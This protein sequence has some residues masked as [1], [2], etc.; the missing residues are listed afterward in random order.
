M[1]SD[2]MGFCTHMTLCWLGDGSGCFRCTA[3]NSL[4]HFLPIIAT[5]DLTFSLNPGFWEI[6]SGFW[7]WWS[8]V[9][10]G[11]GGTL[12]WC[13]RL[14]F[15]GRLSPSLLLPPIFLCVKFWLTNPLLAGADPGGGGG[16]G[17]LTFVIW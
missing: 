4:A 10:V 9:L 2:R 6:M 17:R 13:A 14:G 7:L 1:E 16:G 15:M 5:P 3:S 8:P 11:G 12:G